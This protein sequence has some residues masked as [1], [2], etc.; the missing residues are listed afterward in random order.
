MTNWLIPAT[1]GLIPAG[2]GGASCAA[3]GNRTADR[4]ALTL[5]R[6]ASCRPPTSPA[7]AAS[8]V[9]PAVVRN[10]RRPRPAS[11][12]FPVVPATSAA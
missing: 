10:A 11:G 5:C 1:F 6:V 4:A 9:T 2:S 7:A 3:R 12:S 8:S